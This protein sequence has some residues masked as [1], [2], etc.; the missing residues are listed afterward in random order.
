M[1]LVRGIINKNWI[2]MHKIKVVIAIKKDVYSIHILV[3][4]VVNQYADIG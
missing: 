1:K 4:L 2:D 3:Q